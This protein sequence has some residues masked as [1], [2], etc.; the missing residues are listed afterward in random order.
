MAYRDVY[1]SWQDDPEG[2][3]MKAADAI[4][5]HTPPTKALFDDK[6]PL[7]EWYRDGRVNT[8]FNALDRHVAAGRGDQVAIIYDS[9]MT[10]TISK[11]TYTDLLTRVAC[12]AGALKAKGIAKGDRVIIYMPMVPEAIEAMLASRGSVRSIRLCLAGLPPTNWPCGLTMPPRKP[13]LRRLAGW[14]PVA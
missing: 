4:D 5:W 10:D 8:C 3:W 12:L 14:N 9:P 7:Y 11:I 6:A 1:K 13:S 2:F